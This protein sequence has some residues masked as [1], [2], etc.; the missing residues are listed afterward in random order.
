MCWGFVVVVDLYY[1]CCCR[2][3]WCLL[4]RCVLTCE[5]LSFLVPFKFSLIEYY[6]RNNSLSHTANT[7]LSPVERAAFV[8]ALSSIV[9]TV[10][11]RV[12]VKT[13]L[14]KYEDLNFSFVK[15][16]NKAE[17]SICNLL[18]SFQKPHVTHCRDRRI[19]ERTFSKPVSL[20]QLA[21]WKGVDVLILIASWPFLP[22]IAKYI[23]TSRAQHI[24]LNM[25]KKKKKTTNFWRATFIQSIQCSLAVRSTVYPLNLWRLIGC[26]ISSSL[27]VCLCAFVT[28]GGD[29]CEMWKFLFANKY[30]HFDATK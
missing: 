9:C 2:C 14:S 4:C 17:Q 20:Y 11:S 3:C 7:D 1:C 15:L 6:K 26:C 30:K 25:Q 18:K 19:D 5:H 22:K 16:S 13:Q 8:L 27:F 23:V 29:R 28:K 21:R 10:L 24:N 12:A